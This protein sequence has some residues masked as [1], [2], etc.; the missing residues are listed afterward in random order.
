MLIDLAA[1][2]APTRIAQVDLDV[3]HHRNRTLAEL[4]PQAMAIMQTVLLPRRP[5][6][7]SA[8]GG[9]LVRP[10]PTVAIESSRAPA[11]ARGGRVPRAHCLRPPKREPGSSI[12]RQRPADDLDRRQRCERRR[13][14]SAARA[15]PAV[16]HRRASTVG[17]RRRGVVEG[18]RPPR[19]RP[20]FPSVR[21]SID[22]SAH[23]LAVEGLL[24]EET[25]TG[26]DQ[27]RPASSLR[28]D[29][30]G[31]GHQV[32]PAI[33]SAPGAGQPAG[34]TPRGARAVELGRRRRRSRRGTPAA[35]AAAAAPSSST[36]AAVAPFCG[37]NARAASRKCVRTSHATSIA[38]AP[39]A[40]SGVEGPQR[41]EPAVGGG[42]A[43]HADDDVVVRPHRPRR[44][45][46]RPCLGRRCDRIVALGPAHQCEPRRRGHLDHRRTAP[47]SRQRRSTG[48]PSGPV[49]VVVR[50][51]PPSTS[52]VPSP[53]SARGTCDDLVARRAQSP[54]GER[55]AASAALERAPELVGRHE[56]P[57]RTTCE[58]APRPGAL[59]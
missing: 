5:R 20:A 59:S 48:S 49:T 1:R 46:A 22:H 44:R 9:H 57:H 37:P 17:S 14:Q 31:L 29:P 28:P 2:S 18:T 33:S 4:G 41:T 25:L 21:A 26:D 13:P 36:W 51:A 34:E 12:A 42:R 35:S 54:S 24:V 58:E 52:R 39:A 43:A 16:L 6:P 8:I 3:R 19:P 53:P 23:D 11:D 10:G 45:S 15:C 40:C 55:A 56:D 50:F 7:G 32:E 38:D 30:D 27:R 47:H